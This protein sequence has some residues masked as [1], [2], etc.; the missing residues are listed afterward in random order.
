MSDTS[1]ETR[2][3]SFLCFLFKDPD[4]KKKH[5]GIFNILKPWLDETWLDEYERSLQNDTRNFQFRR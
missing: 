2:A 1:L 4:F 5:S 3:R